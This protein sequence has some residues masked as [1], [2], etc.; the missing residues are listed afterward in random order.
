MFNWNK[1]EKPFAS[2]GGFG[3]GGLG[4]A[5]GSASSAV[6]ASGGSVVEPGNGFVYHVFIANGN[7][8]RT[9]DSLSAVDYLVVAGGG[10][11]V[12]GTS[13]CMMLCACLCI[14]AY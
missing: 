8:E 5:G 10:G 11:V 14:P 7:F 9:V 6:K 2:F 3:G 4:L 12:L 13:T 1:K